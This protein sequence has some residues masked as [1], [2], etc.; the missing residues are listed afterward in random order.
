M[1]KKYLRIYN[2][3]VKRIQSNS[4]T[5][6]DLLPSENELAAQYDTSRETI[7]KA[8]DLLSQN[9]YIQKVR[10]KGSVIINRNQFS[11]PVSGIESFTE[12]TEKMALNSR[13]IVH[14]IKYLDPKNESMEILKG[15]PNE[16]VWN[17]NRIREIDGEKVILD[18]D[19]FNDKYIPLLTEEICQG[20][21]YNY[22][23]NELGLVIGFA[24]KEIVVENPTEEDR[25]LLD[26]EG[27][28]NVVV[29]RSQVHLDD[30]S[31]FQI[32][33]SRHRPDKFRFVDF[34]R[35]V[36]N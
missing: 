31:L 6:G 9:G 23:E 29:I 18:K 2:D 8:L 1:Q 35:R 22:I 7:R 21:I 34:A 26:L 25:E 36:K 17:V 10:G 30:A 11:F 16:K 19:Y 5:I 12:L 24:Q 20:S 13:T 27:F 33:E 4:W 15:N 3:L 32:T 14:S 28:S